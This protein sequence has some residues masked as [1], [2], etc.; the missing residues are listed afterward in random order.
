MNKEEELKSIRINKNTHK[1]LKI[2]CS[3]NDFK[4]NFLLEKIILEYIEKNEKK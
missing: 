2:F 3:E 4:I 1:K